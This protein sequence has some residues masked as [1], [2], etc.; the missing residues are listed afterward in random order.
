MQGRGL[1]KIFPQSQTV[2]LSHEVFPWNGEVSRARGE[3]RK[4]AC[5]NEGLFSFRQ[6]WPGEPYQEAS[7]CQFPNCKRQGKE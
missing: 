4:E 2:A 6:G 1:F 7:L 3:P 5:P